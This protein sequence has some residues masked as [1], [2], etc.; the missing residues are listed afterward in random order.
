M[1]VAK[2]K[3]IRVA[4]RKLRLLSDLVRGKGIG[5]ALETLRFSKR[6]RAA[7]A[8]SNVLKSAVANAGQTG[9]IDTEILLVKSICVD[10][11]P[12]MKRYR[13]RAQGRASRISKRTSH[14]SVELEER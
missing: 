8:L 13:P 4:P 11:G 7:M 2:A 1:A 3:Y 14:I 12:T 6:R 9:K 10:Q 5:E